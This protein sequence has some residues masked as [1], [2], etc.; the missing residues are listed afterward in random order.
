VNV[1]TLIR[2]LGLS[3]VTPCPDELL[4]QVH[5]ISLTG[6]ELVVVCLRWLGVVHARIRPCAAS[7]VPDSRWHVAG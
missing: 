6:Y 1:R 7:H 5:S 4:N 3:S 2:T